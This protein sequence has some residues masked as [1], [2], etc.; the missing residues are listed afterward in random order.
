[1]LLIGTP[2]LWWGGSLALIF[3]LVMWVGARDWRFGL[4]VVGFGSTWLPWLAYDDR[5]IFLFYAVVMLPF[6]VLALTLTMGKLIGRSHVPHAA[7]YRRGGRRRLVLRAGADELRVV[8][9]DLDRRS[10][11]PLGV[12]RPDLV[13]ALDLVQSPNAIAR[14][15]LWH[16][17]CALVP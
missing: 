1:M 17:R 14:G 13:P 3:A 4:S 9:A 16:G 12:A 11:H 5:P 15:T 7:S 6:L 10:A 8:L 2:A